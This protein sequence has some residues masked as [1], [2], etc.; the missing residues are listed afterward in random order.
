[1]TRT[2]LA[3]L[4]RLGTSTLALPLVGCLESPQEPVAY[5]AVAVPDPTPTANVGAWSL[6]LTRAELAFGPIYFC[7]SASGSST[8][9][10]ASIAEATDTVLIDALSSQTQRIGRVHGFTGTI[11]SVSY[12]LGIDWFDTQTAPTPAEVA[13]GGHSLHLEG[14]ARRQGALLPF[15]ADVDVIP[16]KGRGYRAVDSVPA[17]VD[18]AGR[19]AAVTIDSSNFRLEVHFR[20]TNWF[21]QFEERDFDALAASGASPVRITPGSEPAHARFVIGLTG[22][23]RPELRWVPTQQ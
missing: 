21:R 11:R 2:F 15:I 14:E 23:G 16:P 12:N 6:R 8:L 13:P 4:T 19:P 5:D 10:E 18:D 17:L 1:M 20:A 9:C 7:A 3:T 22:L